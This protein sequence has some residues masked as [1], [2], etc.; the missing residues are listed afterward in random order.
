MSSNGSSVSDT[1]SDASEPT[2][3]SIDRLV[4]L[5]TEYLDD[6]HL[7]MSVNGGNSAT[8]A[9]LK[10]NPLLEFTRRRD[11]LKT[12]KL[13]CLVYIE[14]KKDKLTA[15]RAQLLF[16]TSYLRRPTYEQIEPHL[17]DF[18]ENPKQED[19][20]ASTKLI[21]RTKTKFF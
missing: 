6:L 4:Q 11:Q 3:D 17:I 20:K 2:P 19:L 5:V 14:I 16:I 15:P 21:L 8:G 10:I 18:I 1:L 7:D 9:R 12:F 13:Q